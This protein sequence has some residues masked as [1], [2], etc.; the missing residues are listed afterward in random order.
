MVS[1]VGRAASEGKYEEVGLICLRQ[2]WVALAFVDTRRHWQF[3]SENLLNTFK[4]VI[5][6]IDDIRRTRH[7]F[8]RSLDI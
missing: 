8:T 5:I 1:R 3:A 7:L 4:L 2:L 6:Y